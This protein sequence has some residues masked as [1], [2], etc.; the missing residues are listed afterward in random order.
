MGAAPP[1]SFV[2][3]NVAAAL[4]II[5]KGKESAFDTCE[6]EASTSTLALNV[7]QRLQ[8]GQCSL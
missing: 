8:G 7:A 2:S 3:T 6:G 1:G 5:G 4:Y